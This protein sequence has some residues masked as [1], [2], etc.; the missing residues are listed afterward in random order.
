[1]A[2][3]LARGEAVDASTRADLPLTLTGIWRA[4]WSEPWSFKWMCIYVF[5]EYVRPQQMYPVFQFLPWAQLTI[6]AACIAFVAEGLPVRSKTVA[7]VLLL[8]FSTVILLSS[9]FAYSPSIAYNNLD[10][11]ANWLV[12]FFLLANTTTDQRKFF[13]FIVLFLLWSAKMSQHGARAF[14]TGSGAAGG[15]PGWF[16]N[17][18]EYALQMCIFVPL[19][20]Y[21][22]VGLYPSLSRKTVAVLALFPIAGILGIVNSGSRGGLLALA[23]V[24]LWMLMRSRHKIRGILA[25]AVAVPLIWMIVPPAL[26]ERFRTAGEDETSTARVVYWKRG[27]EMAKANPFLGVGYE[28]WV[29]Y[30]RVHYPPKEGEFVRWISATEYATE[31]SHNS[32]IEV[33][34]Q[35][36]YTG[37]L[38]FAA[39]LFSVWI[40]NARTRRILKALGERGRFLREMSLGVD[41]GVIAFIVAGFFMAVAFY[42]FVWFQLGMAAAL[43][44]SASRTAS[45]HKGGGGLQPQ[46]SATARVAGWRSRRTISVAIR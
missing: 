30:Y 16:T 32:F 14:L 7:N 1:M 37:L 5:F 35:L 2:R 25:L 39:M 43:H 42:P 34:S 12:V 4:F 10:K 45:L 22:I 18:G 23:C 13:L 20:L 3:V 6:T 28:N 44:V 17:T 8:L 40:I 36:G 26:K 46:P 33:V 15:S 21:F 29:P 9:V 24:G 41:A 38:L 27:L 11:F 19:S 31:V